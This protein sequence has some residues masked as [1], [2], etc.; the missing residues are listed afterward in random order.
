MPGPCTRPRLT[1]VTLSALLIAGV[2]GATGQAVAAPAAKPAVDAVKRI[3]GVPKVVKLKDVPLSTGRAYSRTPGD[4]TRSSVVAGPSTATPRSN[5]RVVCN[6][7]LGFDSSAPCIQAKAAFQSAID[8]W[9]AIVA[10]PIE[11]NLNVSFA[12]L[13]ESV[14]GS[15]YSPYTYTNTAN[16][17]LHVSALADA[18]QSRDIAFEDYGVP[19]DP[20]IDAEFTTDPSINWYFGTDGLTPPGQVDFKSVVLHEIGHGLGVS[21]TMDVDGLGAGSYGS[22]ETGNPAEPFKPVGF[23]KEAFNAATAGARLTSLVAAGGSSATLGTTLT[24]GSVYWGGTQGV[25]AAG[26]SRPRLYA[27]SPW[28]PGSSFAHLDEDTYPTGNANSLMTPFLTNNEAVHTPGP[29]AVGMLVDQ[30]WT[31]SLPAP[32]TPALPG[33][34]TGVTGVRGNQSVQV[35]WNAAAANNSAISGY[36]V[37]AA[38]G[39]AT[40][41]TAALTCAVTGLT[42]GTAYTFTV[43]ATNGIG[44][45]PASAASAAVTPATL[46]SAPTSVTGTRGNGSVAVSWPAAAGNGSPVTGYTATAAPGGASCT[47]ASL[48]CTVGTLVNGTAYTFTVR[49]TNAVGQGPASPASGSVTPA[50]V[51]AAPAS[52]SGVRG[53]GSVTVSWPAA[54]SNGS[55]VTGYTATAAPGGATCSTAGLS[56]QVSGLANGTA[57]TFTV[58]AT[59]AIGQGPASAAS[60][61]VTPAT[62]P[63]APASVTAARGDRSVT[64]SWPA[65]TNNGAAVTGYRATASPG[66][67]VC[68]TTGALTCSVTGLTNGTAYTF[69]VTATNAVGTGPASAASAAATPADTSA[70]RVTVN[71]TPVYSI[72]NA[73]GVTYSATDTSSGVLNYDVAYKQAAW[74]GAFGG[75]AYP[76]AWQ[77]TTAKSVSLTAARGTTR[78][79]I[80]RSRDKALNVS[81]WSAARCTA[82][83][84]D[85]RHLSAAT[86]WT[87]PANNAAYYASTITTAAK[88]GLVL[89]RTTAKAKQISI[90]ATKC[91]GCGVIGVYLNGVL[92]KQISLNN[93][94]T[95]VHKQI[96]PVITYTA[97]KSGTITIKTLNAGRVNIDG[98]GLSQI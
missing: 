93:A 13:P 16:N 50:A 61:A 75:W 92:Q 29:I 45:G 33:A 68:T 15:A 41:S 11:I 72:A 27:P 76:T 48:G 43:R 40:C 65:A 59:N 28:E 42:N 96:I 64:V 30:G 49:A 36:Q 74:N 38:P 3:P 90:V 88:S 25:S 34:P 1:A 82:S 56:C 62:V 87:R 23:D 26:G 5:W 24:S 58:R 70:P 81:A 4:G 19:N 37:T 63:A 73:Y 17:T 66:G 31:A 52:V 78:C 57:Y 18:L 8:I 94:G 83:P 79:F 71:A 55:A 32:A 67:L 51:P 14:L 97:V 10:S 44:Q 80:V 21:G 86:G 22:K 2:L 60:A 98:L 20:D 12:A 84:L 39:G 47:T 9:R 35:S 7:A 46:P 77:K 6:G 89:T 95:T 91:N 54:A 85:D 69:T 53:N